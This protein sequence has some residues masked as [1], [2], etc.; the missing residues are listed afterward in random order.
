MTIAEQLNQVADAL[1]TWAAAQGGTAEVAA[2]PFHLLAMLQHKPGSVRAVVLFGGEQKRGEFEETGA[3]DRGFSVILSRGRGFTAEPSASLVKGAA[4][5]RPLFDLVEEARQQIR[6]LSFA[7]ETTEVTPN[8][9]GCELF[10]S[11][12]GKA[13]D[14]YQLNFQIGV[15]LPAATPESE[16]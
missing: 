3:V 9:L 15:Q 6:G 13:V 5:G 4:G 11:A 7:E 14:A 8:Y 2:D 1:K 16:N 10:P 12:E